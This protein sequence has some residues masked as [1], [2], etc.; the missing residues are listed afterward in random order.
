ML[1]KSAALKC[2]WQEELLEGVEVI[3]ADGIRTV[4]ASEGGLYRTT[5]AGAT[6][7]ARIK[8]IPYYAWANRGRNEMRVWLNEKE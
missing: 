5:K 4:A 1:P 3:E 2:S 7:P 8:M 6:E